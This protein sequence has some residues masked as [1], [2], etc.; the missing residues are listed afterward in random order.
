MKAMYDKQVIISV[1]V[2]RTLSKLLEH[3]HCY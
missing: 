3:I 2:L 1:K